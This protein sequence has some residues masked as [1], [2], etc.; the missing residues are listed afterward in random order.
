MKNIILLLFV[1]NFQISANVLSQ[2]RIDL[3]LTDATLKECIKMIEKKSTL[4]FLYN[5]KKIRDV[6]GINISVQDASVEEILEMVL[7]DTHFIHSIKNDI[8]LISPREEKE[9][10][11]GFLQQKTTITGQVLNEKGVPIPY[12]AIQIK[13]TAQGTVCNENGN[14]KI[15]IDDPN[16]ILL[17]SSVG[18]ET[19][20]V[21]P[22]EKKYLSITLQKSIEDIS[23][24]IVT[25]YQ[26]ISVEKSTGSTV[27]ITAKEIEKKGQSNILNTIEGL[28]SGLGISSDPANEGNKRF[29][30]RGVATINGNSSP[31]II[32][33]GFP[34]ETDISLLNPYEIESINVLKDAAA[35]SI[36]GARSANGVIVITTKR[37]KKGKTQVNYTNNFTFNQK[38]DLAYRM[39]RVSSSDLVDIQKI[40]AGSNPRTY[41]YYINNSPAYA[42]YF[43]YARNIV[44]EAMAQ[45]N[46]GTITQAQAD[47]KLEGLRSID[48]LSQLKEIFT[49]NPFEEQHNLSVSGGGDNN[50]YRVSLNYTHNEGSFT[51]DESERILF[52]VLNNIKISNKVRVDI[53]G[54]ISMNKNENIPYD[55]DV[56]L[57]QV[58]SYELF[59]DANGNPLPVRIGR[60]GSGSTDNAGLFG[61]KDVTELNRLLN[62]GLL[63]ENYYPVKE[64]NNYSNNIKG[65][66]ARMQARLYADIVNGLKGIFGFQYE[67]ASSKNTRIAES[68]SYEI[69]Q[70]VNNTSPKNFAGDP[71]ALN[72]PFG[73]RITETRSDRHSYT[74][75]GQLDFNRTFGDHNIIALTGSEIRHIFNSSNT[76]DKFG[77]DKNTLL[78]HQVDARSLQGTL[79]NVNHPFGYIA[80]GIPMEDDFHEKTDRFFSLYGNFS[81]DYKRKYILSG[82]MRIDQ[83]NLFGTAPEYRYKPFWSVGGKWRI[84]EEPFFQSKQ[85]SKLALRMSHGINGNI[86]NKFGPFNIATSMLN[87]RAGLVNSLYISSPSIEDLRWERS[88]TT[89]I[90]LDVT[91]LNRKLDFSVDYYIKKTE[92]IL[93]S[94]KADPSQGFSNLM[95]NDA[96]IKNNGI[97]FT[98]RSNNIQAAHF[99]WNTNLTF[100]YNKNRV[101]KVLHEEDYVPF[102]ASGLQNIEGKP[103]QSFYLYNWAGL[104]EKGQVTIYNA[105]GNKITVDESIYYGGIFSPSESVKKED[106]VYSGTSEPKFT[107]ALSNNLSYKNFGLSF[108]FVFSGGHV[109]LNDTYNGEYVGSRPA[110]VH[111]DAAMAWEKEGDELKTDIPSINA[112]VYAPTVARYST[113]NIIDGDYIKL[114]ELILTYNIPPKVLKKLF[115][116]SAVVSFRGN[117]LFYWA[118]NDEGIDPE[119][120]GIALRFFPVKPSYSMGINISF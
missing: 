23:E 98:V 117:N 3:D 83:S 105:Q 33:D 27:T 32:V 109:L 63:D 52:D 39:N 46:E 114:R 47:S 21:K 56:L 35:A 34:I 49:Q 1:F 10:K 99:N 81:Y 36:Y 37:G 2:T 53:G 82:S 58:S 51:G 78:F 25:G 14:F 50:N 30:I 41:Q 65:F 92:D 54:N 91:M 86:A 111:A 59:K 19:V 95:K 20:E 31:L 45:L 90:G 93:A 67:T 103:T 110:K 84:N 77:F 11:P 112:H 66:S 108:M 119:A 44:Y 71:M 87:Y 48:N 104:D 16:P 7:K 70:I 85:V 57:N 73:A 17:I 96:N 38:P 118:K 55:K 68:G 106:L 79:E 13:G 9:Q 113:K 26:N 72:I 40:G 80:G 15:T 5:S 107:G 29:N 64:I 76:T 75:R 115:M 89:N 42:S 88:A 120:H 74:L 97:E 60:I 22:G 101:T 69:A 4:G 100:R 102:I 6:K 116:K 94:G 24:V 12:A 62:M 18:F 61:G 43:V 28:V 8:I